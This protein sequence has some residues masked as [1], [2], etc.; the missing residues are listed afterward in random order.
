ME[1]LYSTHRRR[2]E[3]HKK[4]WLKNLKGREKA[5]DLGID[6]KSKVKGKVVPVL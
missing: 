6:G 1:G 2:R 5:E 4:F 3:K